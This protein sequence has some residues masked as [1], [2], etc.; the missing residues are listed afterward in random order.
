MSASNLPYYVRND[1]E[2]G[3]YWVGERLVKNPDSP[4]VEAT[5]AGLFEI[6]AVNQDVHKRLESGSHLDATEAM[7][8]AE[9]MRRLIETTVR[10]AERVQEIRHLAHDAMEGIED[11]SEAIK[12]IFRLASEA[13]PDLDVD[14]KEVFDWNP[15]PPKPDPEDVL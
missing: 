12:E 2:L 1:E 7:R 15:R 11:E 4:R 8:D 10:R 6:E 3:V 5:D 14:M 9:R 13:L